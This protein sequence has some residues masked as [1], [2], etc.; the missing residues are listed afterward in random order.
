MFEQQNSSL[1]DHELDETTLFILEQEAVLVLEGDHL[2]DFLVVVFLRVVSASSVDDDAAAVLDVLESLERFVQVADQLGQLVSSGLADMA[3]VNNQHDFDLLVDVQ[4]P[5]Y[6]EGVGDLE[7]LAL[8]VLEARAVIEG[9]ILDYHLG[10]DRSLG[11]LLVADFD[12]GLLHSVE[13]GLESVELDDQF[14]AAEE[15]HDGAFADTGVSDH[16]DCLVILFVDGDGFHAVV[17]ELFEFVEV[18]G[19]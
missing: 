16:D 6:E 18:D 7:L 17:D 5:L 10:R 13:D 12:S 1:A 2:L 4:Q 14:G 15:G 8:V 11:V 9:H 3:F 19:V